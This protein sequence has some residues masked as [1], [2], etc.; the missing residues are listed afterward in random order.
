MAIHDSLTDKPSFIVHEN[1]KILITQFVAELERRQKLIVKDVEDS[2]PKPD[3]FDM[4]PDRMQKDWERWINQVPVIGFNSGKY[5]LNLIEKYFVEELAKAEVTLLG[6]ALKHPEIFV[7]RKENDYMFLT[8]DKFQFLDIKN[9]LGGGMS[10]YKWCK[11]LDCKLEKLVFPYE[12]LRNYKKLRHVGPVKRQDFYSSLTKKTISRQEYRKFRS[13][14]YKRGCVA[15]LDWLREY[16]VADVEPFIEAV[17]KT[18]HQYFDDQLNILKDAVSIP[19]I[20]QRYVLN[21]ALKKRLN[22][23]FM[24]RESHAITSVK[25]HVTRK[26]AKPAKKSKR[27]VKNAQRIELTRYCIAGQILYFV[28][29]ASVERHVQERIFMVEMVKSVRQF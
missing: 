14:F 23:S 6:G 22:M 16:N 1:P 27:N 25:K 2:Y 26:V 3:H 17:D 4:L 21:K 29:T 19:G 13:E 18:R 15:M 5:D 28:D 11:S 7:A 10:Y 24:H 20:S 12:W 9:F 8:T